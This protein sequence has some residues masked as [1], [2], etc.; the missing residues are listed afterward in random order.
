MDTAWIAS[1]ESGVYDMSYLER[2]ARRPVSWELSP[3]PRPAERKSLRGIDGQCLGTSS[4][5]GEAQGELEGPRT[6]TL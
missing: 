2:A 3:S 6:S 1:P 4:A 5:A